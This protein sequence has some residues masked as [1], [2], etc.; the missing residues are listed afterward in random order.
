MTSIL[1]DLECTPRY[2]QSGEALG[3]SKQCGRLGPPICIVPSIYTPML[4]LKTILYKYYVMPKPI[5]VY[6]FFFT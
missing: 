6:K 1:F 5:I 4:F 2:P 3:T